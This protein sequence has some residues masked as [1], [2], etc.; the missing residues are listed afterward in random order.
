MDKYLFRL[1]P[2]AHFEKIETKKVVAEIKT[3][4]ETPSVGVYQI[5]LY[6]NK[7]HMHKITNS[8]L[9]ILKGKAYVL[10]DGKKT[11]VKRGSFIY[12]PKKI[13]HSWK[14]IKPHKYIEYIEI[15]NPSSANTLFKDVIWAKNK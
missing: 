12:I 1:Q 9:Y 13:F 3:F 14:P 15:N 11:I 4:I 10:I 8:L 6:F 7:L 5:R 2:F